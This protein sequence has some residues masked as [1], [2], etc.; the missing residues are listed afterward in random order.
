LPRIC[1]ITVQPATAE[2]LR[3]LPT[4]FPTEAALIQWGGPRLRF[5]LDEPQLAAIWA[6]SCQ[7]PPRRLIWSGRLDDDTVAAHAQV[8]MDYAARKA[9]LARIGIAPDFRGQGLAYPFMQRII[10]RLDEQGEIS[11]LE[12]NVYAFNQPALRLYHRLGFISDEVQPASITVG[13]ESWDVIRMTRR[14]H[15]ASF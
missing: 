10:D 7:T 6:E 4:W 15:S 2:D 12:L 8:V 5:P 14:M 13:G 11:T 1:P 9:R 3:L